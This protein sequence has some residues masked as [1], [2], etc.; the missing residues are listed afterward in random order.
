MVDETTF[1]RVMIVC[2]IDEYP[3][4][5]NKVERM[6]GCLGKGMPTRPCDIF[7]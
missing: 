4:T 7:N 1:M 5:V 2:L 6:N 3:T